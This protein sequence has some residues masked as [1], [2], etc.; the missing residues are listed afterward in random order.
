MCQE[1][2]QNERE[3]YC[4]CFICIKMFCSENARIIHM[5][6]AHDVV[7]FKTPAL[8]NYTSKPKQADIYN[9]NKYFNYQNR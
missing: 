6:E 9:N 7:L 1:E 4:K 8:A 3:F 2:Y 5:S